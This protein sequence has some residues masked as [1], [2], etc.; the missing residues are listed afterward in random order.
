MTDLGIGVLRVPFQ[1]WQLKGAC[2]VGFGRRFVWGESRWAFDERPIDRWPDVK[3]A[4]PIP[5]FRDD[6]VSRHL[7]HVA[8]VWSPLDILLNSFSIV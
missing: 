8:A 3:I 2:E 1:G 5:G 7:A 4:L 6:K